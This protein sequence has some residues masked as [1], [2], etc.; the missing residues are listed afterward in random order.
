[1]A[2]ERATCLDRV[3]HAKVRRLVKGRVADRRVLPRIDR[4]LQAGARTGA[5]LEATREGTPPG[6]PRS[7]GRAHRLLDGLEKERARRGPRFVRSADDRPLAVPRARAGARGGARMTRCLD[8]PLPRTVHQA[9]RAVARPGQRTCLGLSC[10]RPRRHRRRGREQA[11][12]ALKAE[13]RH[14]TVRTRG[15]TLAQ[16]VQDRR[17]DLAGWHASGGC[18][19]VPAPLQEGDSWRRRRLRGSGWQPW[20]RRRARARRHR[21]VS[22]DRAWQTSQAA[23]GPWRVRRSPARAM[24][25]PGRSVDSRGVPRLHRYDRRP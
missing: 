11:L 23:H 8:R 24:A 13:R 3:Q 16:V 7:P 5:H 20:G 9:P 18:A 25:C 12:Q 15:V 6:G 2:L 10:P 19:A 21:G 14:R 22:Q 1:V 17:R 4:Y